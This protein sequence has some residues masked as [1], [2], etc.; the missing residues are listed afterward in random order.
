AAYS[1]VLAGP[2][3]FSRSAFVQASSNTYTFLE[4]TP[5]PGYTGTAIEFQN[6]WSP[7]ASAPVTVVPGASATPPVVL[8]YPG[9]GSVQLRVCEA[10][11]AGTTCPLDRPRLAGASVKL[12]ADGHGPDFV[13][14]GGTDA[15]GHLAIQNVPGPHFRLKVS[16]PQSASSAL[17]VGGDIA[18]EGSTAAEEAQLVTVGTLTG[19]LRSR[20]GLSPGLGGAARGVAGRAGV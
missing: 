18:F 15:A 19:A 17:E 7:I 6:G 5:G 2:D 16:H 13:P 1:L 11:A 12:Q 14:V 9:V 3:G 8:T 4:V 20:D 10:A